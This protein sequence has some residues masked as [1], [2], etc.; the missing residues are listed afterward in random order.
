MNRNHR[1]RRLSL[2]FLLCSFLS[3][4]LAS[5]I[6]AENSQAD[7]VNL[8]VSKS[9]NTPLFSKKVPLREGD[10]VLDL[11]RR[12][13]EI[14][15]AHAG[16]FVAQ[17]NHIPEEVGMPSDFEWFYYVNGI[18]ASIG[19]LGYY[20]KTGESIWWDYHRWKTGIY[21]SA[22]VGQFPEPFRSGYQGEIRPTQIVY[23][24]GLEDEAK[25]LLAALL[26][27]GVNEVEAKPLQDQIPE[28]TSHYYIV[29]APWDAFAQSSRIQ[30]ALKEPAKSGFHV[31]FKEDG[32]LLATSVKEDHSIS[33]KTL[34]FILALNPMFQTSPL[35]LVSGNN[36]SSVKAVNQ[37]LL[38][39][40]SKLEHYAAVVLADGRLIN[41][42]LSVLGN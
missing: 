11:L 23:A 18:L 42:P 4:A 8:H 3:L 16:A 30:F 38:A 5:P 14:Q 39:S 25:Q 2:C 24:P 40:P 29:L 37:L 41:V 28:D 1:P 15:T 12:H 21:V 22:V 33:G 27:S 31:R 35:W 19:A 36:L 13:T 17:I 34:G 10:S 7:F 6:R 26:K 9:F 32:S 20:P